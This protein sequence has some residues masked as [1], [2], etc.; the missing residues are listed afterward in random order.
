LLICGVFV[1]CICFY[2]I[3]YSNEYNLIQ[4]LSSY[5][6]TCV[7]LSMFFGVYTNY[8]RLGRIWIY[9]NLA[10][11][12]KAFY[13]IDPCLNHPCLRHF[14][15]SISLYFTVSGPLS[16]FHQWLLS[17]TLQYECSLILSFLLT[18]GLQWR[19]S[20]SQ[21]SHREYASQGRA[22]CYIRV[23]WISNYTFIFLLIYTG[24]VLNICWF[25]SGIPIW[26][27]SGN[28]SIREAMERLTDREV[29]LQ[30]TLS[31]NR[32]AVY[33]DSMHSLE[34]IRS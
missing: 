24:C 23:Y 20:Q 3:Y 13:R 19:V 15:L 11:D 21:Q 34:N 32:S 31:L 18:A 7:L 12:H 1:G 6:L 14:D 30:T 29:L 26:R 25:F 17:P 10:L 4:W 8:L 2:D 22:L 28:W 9:D 16:P 27:V 5:A 33:L